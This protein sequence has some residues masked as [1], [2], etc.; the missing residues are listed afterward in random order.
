M[1]RVFMGRLGTMPKL[2]YTK[3]RTP[4]C[5]LSVGINRIEEKT[6]W[7]KVIVWGKQA[8]LCSVHLK[9][10]SE[11][12]IKGVEEEKSYQNKSGETKTYKEVK[13]RLVGFTDL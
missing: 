12:F 11:I 13:A 1:E 9:T 6:V 7:E 2:A 4:V 10:G 3:N 5:E 8:E